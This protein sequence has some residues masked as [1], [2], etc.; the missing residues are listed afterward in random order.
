MASLGP[1]VDNGFFSTTEVRPRSRPAQST[2][3]LIALPKNHYQKPPNLGAGFSAL[4]LRGHDRPIRANLVADEISTET[5]R[6]AI[7]TW[8]E[9]VLY[10][11][12]ATWIEH[13]S[14]ARECIFGEFDTQD[15]STDP[16][17]NATAPKARM[18]RKNAVHTEPTPQQYSKSF[19][20]PTP[21][22]GPPQVVCWLNRLDL[23]SGS[24]TDY[25]IRAYASDITDES[26]VAHLD[27]WDQG[28]LNGAAMCWIAFPRDKKHVDSGI[29]STHDVRK[30][31]DPRAKNSKRVKFK[32]KFGRKP[33]VLVALNEINMA[34]N[35]DLRVKAYVDEVDHSGFRWHLDS[36]SESTLYA[37]SASWIAL[38]FA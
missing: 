22:K 15:G 29:F 10:A 16:A 20:F 18:T 36:W 1:G 17:K 12:S 8:G 2:S 35:A 31:Y 19:F 27:T 34:G 33:T 23:A 28:I 5:F 9:S 3:R 14:D 37:A 6:I 32:Q 7:E 24:D 25:K 21:F 30:I 38:G 26:F 4:D 11:A 13:K